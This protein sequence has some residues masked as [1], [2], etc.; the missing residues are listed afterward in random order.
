[1]FE[2]VQQWI[3]LAMGNG[4]DTIRCRGYDIGCMGFPKERIFVVDGT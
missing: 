1:M 3:V 2:V 4:L